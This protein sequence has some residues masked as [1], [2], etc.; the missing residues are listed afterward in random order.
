MKINKI[1]WWTLIV[2]WSIPETVYT[3]NSF[4]II[5]EPS[6]VANYLLNKVGL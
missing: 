1:F 3:V 5:K 2:I 6:K 4:G